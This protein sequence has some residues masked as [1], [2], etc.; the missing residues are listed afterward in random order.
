MHS[1]L[2]RD[3]MSSSVKIEKMGALTVSYMELILQNVAESVLLLDNDLRIVWANNSALQR[4]NKSGDYAFGKV[5]C[6][7]MSTNC[8][9]QNAQSKK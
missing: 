6:G 5:R 8:R 7:V 9:T 4:I 3:E 2:G 1:Y